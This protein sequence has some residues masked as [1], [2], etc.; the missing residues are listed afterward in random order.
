MTNEQAIA[1]FDMLKATVKNQPSY[2]Y[3]ALDVA[4]EALKKADYFKHVTVQQPKYGDCDGWIDR[5][6]MLLFL[7]PISCKFAEAIG[8]TWKEDDNVR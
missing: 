3:E 1:V 5:Q 2:V 6:R 7:D 8:I 4:Y